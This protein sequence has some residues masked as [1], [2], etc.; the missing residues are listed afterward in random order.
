MPRVLSRAEFARLA[1]VSKV[2]ITKACRAGLAPACAADRVDAEHPAAVAYLKRRGVAIARSDGTP[3]RSKKSSPATPAAPTAL[4]KRA[5]KR[6]KPPTAPGPEP[7]DPVPADDPDAYAALLDPLIQRFGTARNFRDW[8][9]SR[10]D[11]ETLRKTRLD[12]EQTEGR[13]ISRDLV[14]GHMF[15]LID[16]LTRRLLSDLPKTA[17]RRCYANAESKVAVE[18][19]EKMVTELVASML[20]P[21]KTTL[22]KLLR[23]TSS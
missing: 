23:D 14:K 4:P 2:A 16:A 22:A 15:G 9:L 19:S 10:K 21:V 17:T 13:L 8:L 12:N 6:K 7:A 5:E 1:K 11:L 20:E 3:T 18:E